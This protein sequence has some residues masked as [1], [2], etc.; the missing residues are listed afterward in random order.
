MNLRMGSKI[1]FT[2]EMDF[3]VLIVTWF[4]FASYFRSHAHRTSL[5]LFHA[6]VLLT[7]VVSLFSLIAIGYFDRHIPKPEM[8]DVVSLLFALPFSAF[9]AKWLL[10]LTSNIPPIR[11]T[12]AL[13][14]SVW[15]AF[16]FESAQII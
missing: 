1:G 8:S 9:V 11:Y 3:V 4:L 12:E 14:A 15:V 2:K 10:M 7:S 5:G 6:W 16:V 13:Q